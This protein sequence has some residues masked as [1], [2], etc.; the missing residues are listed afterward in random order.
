M[1]KKLTSKNF[2]SLA[3][4]QRLAQTRQSLTE[5]KI[6]IL[7]GCVILENNNRIYLGFQM[8]YL[9]KKRFRKN[10]FIHID[11]LLTE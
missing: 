5:M 11:A 4:R 9:Q 6:L 3:G 7:R 8:T 1:M 10:I 2:R